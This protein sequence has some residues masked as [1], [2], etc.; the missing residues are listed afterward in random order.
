MR[1]LTLL[2]LIS[3]GFATLPVGPNVHIPLETGEESSFVIRISPEQQN[4]NNYFEFIGKTPGSKFAIRQLERF[5]DTISVL[6]SG[7]GDSLIIRLCDLL[8]SMIQNP[9]RDHYAIGSILA[10]ATPRA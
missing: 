4:R 10:K 8:R 5:R 2:P 6:F 3:M 1:Y 7:Q 9:E